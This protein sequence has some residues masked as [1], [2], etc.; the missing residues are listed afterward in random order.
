[1]KVNFSF[2]LMM[3]AGLL[4]FSMTNRAYA[5]VDSG[6]IVGQVLD[7]K[8]QAIAGATITVKNERTG[9]ERSTKSGADG[10]YQVAA[11]SP[12][13]YTVSVAADQ[14]APAVEK[15]LQLAVGQEIRR[16]F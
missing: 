2:R 11:L 15:S 4:C 14:F 12:S 5:Q 10:A 1:M 7:V 16:N 8:A 3:M 13:L 9:E 6:K